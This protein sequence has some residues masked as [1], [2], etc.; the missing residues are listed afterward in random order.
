MEKL[1]VALFAV[2]VCALLAMH[3]NSYNTVKYDYYICKDSETGIKTNPINERELLS[4]KESSVGIFYDCQKYSMTRREAR[5]ITKM[6][7]GETR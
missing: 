7:S 6:R 5:V 1:V 3:N 2:F 4:M